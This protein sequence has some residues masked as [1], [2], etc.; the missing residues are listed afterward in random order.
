MKY[1]CED[2]DFHTDNLNNFNN[3]I[4]TIKH[5]NKIIKKNNNN[6]NTETLTNIKKPD[7]NNN[8]C[9]NECKNCGKKFKHRSSKSRHQIKCDGNINLVNNKHIKELVECNQKMTQNNEKLLDVV[10]NNN[11]YLYTVSKKAVG[12]AESTLSTVGII[13]KYL[14]KA[15]CIEK[16]IDY[17]K[18]LQYDEYNEETIKDDEQ[19]VEDILSYRNHK[20]L[21]K[22]LGTII[23]EVYKKDNPEK[24]SLWNSDV[25]RK[26]YLLRD[27]V[28]NIPLWITDKSGILTTE[29]VINPLLEKLR[30]ILVE[31][32]KKPLEDKLSH[33]NIVNRYLK[34]DI[35][36]EL[37]KEIDDGKMH[38][39]IGNFIA[40]YFYFD[41]IKFVN[42]KD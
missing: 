32:M 13:M 29:V 33:N 16:N 7:N 34:N 26:N 39:E 18:K 41:K 36:M 24:Q 8:E 22:Y 30:D 23:I 31:Y 5:Q 15:P 14:D 42:K 2:C 10:M 25:A 21:I 19:I 17:H 28:N 35:V 27:L 9:S 11:E 1:N 37:I 12:F 40:P 20:T 4:K 38:E 3:H 6:T